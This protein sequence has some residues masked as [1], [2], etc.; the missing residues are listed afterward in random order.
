MSGSRCSDGRCQ[1]RPRCF[2]RWREVR[3]RHGLRGV[4]LCDPNWFCVGYHGR[5]RHK[6]LI[7]VCWLLWRKISLTHRRI[8]NQQCHRSLRDGGGQVL[9]EAFASLDSVNVEEDFVT[10]A[11]VMKSPRENILPRCMLIRNAN[12][13]LRSRQGTRREG[14][15][16]PSWSL[17]A[18]LASPTNPAL[19]SSPGRVRAEVP[20]ARTVPVIF[21]WVL[22]GSSCSKSAVRE[23][24]SCVFPSSSSAKGPRHIIAGQGGQGTDFDP[25]GRV[26]CGFSR[27][28]R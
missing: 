1:H 18:L 5:I 28:G 22:G 7:Q 15:H 16:R 14:H 23:P 4:R 11:C 24:S 26:V 25:D 13:P 20:V 27:L 9:G 19:S 2:F 17:E 21:C 3:A 6:W 8:H 12:R 10:G